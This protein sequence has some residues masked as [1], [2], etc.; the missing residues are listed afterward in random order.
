MHHACLQGNLKARRGWSALLFRVDPLIEGLV[1]NDKKNGVNTVSGSSSASEVRWSFGDRVRI[2][3]KPEWGIGSVTR[4]ASACV[5]GEPCWTLTVRF[6]N[7]G[8][9]TLNTSVAMLERVEETTDAGA[10]EAA[11]VIAEAE[12][13]AGDELFG[14]MAKRRVEA[15]MVVLP[16]PCR[17]PF[18]SLAARVTLTLELYRFDDSNRGLVDWAVAQTGLDDPLSQFNRQELETH[19]RKWS[20][21]RDQHLA[22]LVREAKFKGEPV[23]REL[24]RGPAAARTAA[25]RTRIRR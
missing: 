9:K 18:R 10:G 4:V 8:I 13:T 15:L 6:P 2:P 22:K 20:E 11:V 7:A 12:M 25:A 16:E 5:K 19:F 21:E 23:D 3:S 1:T 14:P 17:D 24:A